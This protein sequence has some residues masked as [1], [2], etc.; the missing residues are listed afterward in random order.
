MPMLG[1]VYFP[2]DR[3]PVMPG[4]PPARPGLGAIFSGAAEQAY[5]QLRYGLPLQ[6]KTLLEVDTPQ[7]QEYYRAKLAESGV[8][9]QRAAP[10]NLSDV[11]SGRV[12]PLRFAIENLVG[13]VPYMAGGIVGAVG[14]GL[15]AGPAGAVAGAI[16]GGVPQFS[17][18]SSSRA[19]EEQGFLSE[20]AARRALLVAPLQS[21]ADAAIGRF[22]PGASKLF[23]P[24]AAPVKGGF[25]RNA[26]TNAVKA[27]IT[28]AVT[29]PLQQVG[30]RY[31]A[32]LPV[33]GSEALSEY[34][35]A[36]AA[37]FAAGGLIGGAGGFRR[38]SATSK[39]A[40][41]TSNEE[42][43]AH[44]DA[45][46]ALPSPQS[47][48]REPQVPT[49]MFVDANGRAVAGPDGI[50]TLV[51]APVADNTL[52]LTNPV[53][54]PDAPL[55]LPSPET[56]ARQP[57]GPEVTDGPGAF[58]D[59]N[60]RT[61]LGPQG[62]NTLL[63]APV[64]GPVTVPEVDFRT[65]LAE[66][67]KGLRG[68]FVQSVT[69]ENPDELLG[70]V[71]DQVFTEQ[72]TRA[73]TAKFAQRLGIL[74]DKLEPGPAALAIEAQ[75]AERQAGQGP[76]NAAV[77]GGTVTAPPAVDTSPAGVT[78]V[79]PAPISIA[80]PADPVEQKRLTAL[81]PKRVRDGALK[82]YT[83][84]SET[85]LREK[86]L[87]T[88]GNPDYSDQVEEVA[89][90]LGLLTSDDA[91]D[92]T[93]LARKT[94]L[95]S[96]QGLDEIVDAARNQGYD[97]KLASV[98]DRGAKAALS[99]EEVTSFTDFEDMTAYQAGKVWAER[100]TGNE[101][102][103][104][105]L[106]AAET[107]RQLG[108]I[109]GSTNPT[110]VEKSSINTGQVQQ[111]ALNRLLDVADLASV[112]DSDV[113]SLRRMVRDGATPSDVGQ[114]LQQVQGGK[115]LFVQPERRS[116][117]M[118]PVRAD[119][120]AQPIF[121]E[122]AERGQGPQ[123]KAAQAQES[124]TAVDT[125]RLRNLA[126]FARDEKGITEARF[127][128]LNDLLDEGKTAQ[129]A[130][131]LKDFDPDAKPA[132]KRLPTPPEKLD[133]LLPGERSVG[134]A[135]AKFEQAVTGKS[136]ME[137]ADH[138]I[139]RA[140]SRYHREIMRGVKGLAERL[141]KAGVVFDFQIVRPGDP[142][143]ARM[144]RAGNAAL[145]RVTRTPL[146]AEVYLKSMELGGDAGA[147][148]QV[149]AHEMLH[150]VTMSLVN[151]GN[152]VGVSNKTQVGKAVKDLYDLSNAVVAHF[153]TRIADGT[154]N[155]FE[156][157]IYKGQNSLANADE[158]LAWGLTNPNMQ[159]YLASI[160]YKPRQSVL[161]RLVELLRGLLGLDAKY[162]TALTE[163]LRVSEQLFKTPD[164]ELRAAFARNDPDAFATATL[165]AE[166]YAPGNFSSANRTVQAANE[167]TQQVSAMASDMVAK[168]DVRGVLDWVRRNGLGALS[169]NQLDRAYGE[170][171]PGLLDDTAAHGALVAIRNKL[172]L[173]SEN[174]VQS[175]DKLRQSDVKQDR[176]DAE[177]VTSLMQV[178]QYGIDGAKAWEDHTHLGFTKDA[179]TGELTIAKGK[180]AE[181]AAS[182]LLWDKAR[183]DYETL[184]RHKTVGVFEEARA[185]G[186]AQNLARMV[187]Q[188]RT[189]VMND[190]EYALGVAETSNPG[191]RF[192]AAEG[193]D[194]AA[195]ARDF[196][197]AELMDRL[198]A[199]KAYIDQVTG[200]PEGDPKH[201]LT[202]LQGLVAATHE[203]LASMARRPYFHLGRFGDHFAAFT[204][205]KDAKGIADPEAVRHV[206]EVLDKAGFGDVQLSADN[207]NPRVM[208]RTDNRSQAEELGRIGL[209]LKAGKW[210]DPETEVLAGPREKGDDNFGAGRQ[211]P[212]YISKIVEGLDTS[213]VYT[214]DPSMTPAE[215][216]ALAAHKNEAIRLAL[217]AWLD[218]QPDNS[219][220][221]VLAKR[222]QVQGAAKDM[223]RAFAHRQ[224]IGAIHIA[225]TL[226]RPEFVAAQ[227]KMQSAVEEAK[228]AGSKADPY[229]LNDVAVE[230]RRRA[231]GNPINP[232]ADTLDKVRAVAHANFLGLNISSALINTSAMGVTVLPE[233]GKK[234][235]YTQSFHAMRRA[236]PQAFAILNAAR[237]E[238]WAR[239]PKHA[240][241]V[242]ITEN[243]LA[244]ANIPPAIR[245]FVR[246]GVADGI[247]DIG[248]AARQLGQVAEGRGDSKLDTALRYASATSMYTE[249]FAR[250]TAGIAARELHGGT[251]PELHS[252]VRQV[253]KDTL[254]DFSPTNTGRFFGKNSPLLGPVTPIVTQFMQWNLQLTEK[255]YSE[256]KQGF[257]D[258]AATPAAKAEARRFL[259]GHMVA[260]T[261]LA[262]TLGLPFAT[263]FASV[264]EMLL[265]DEDEPFD[266]TAEWRN[267]L[268]GVLGEDMAEVVARGLPRAAGFDVSARAGEAN[269][270]P[271]SELLADKRSWKESVQNSVGRGVG[272]APNM[273]LNWVDGGEKIMNGDVLGGMAAAL[274][275]ALRNPVQAYRL[276]SE[277][278]VDTKGNKLPMTPGA[279]A[280]LWQL[281]GFAPAEKAE[282]SEARLDQS[283]RRGE[284]SR[285]AGTLRQQ[286]V[287]AMIDKDYD[288]AREL[289]AEAAVFDEKNE[290]FAVIPS[291]PGALQRQ[292]TQRTQA[293][294]LK[295][296]LGVSM[297]DVAGQGLTR[298]AN[299]NYAQ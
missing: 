255:L 224:N 73:N 196:W 52:E 236:A 51:A 50:K 269:L 247:F 191:E 22:A 86:V 283:A 174:V 260:V 223:M 217:D 97:G 128:K 291:L 3:L 2:E 92:Y 256:I 215:I 165:E 182:K 16:A 162:D 225:S 78:E 160:E 199:A 108:R 143:P 30:E 229:K 42:L 169:R 137:V 216:K 66:T 25:V 175:F 34:V 276:T 286:I 203:N 230:I 43:M 41:Q 177:R 150:A 151:Y 166:A 172:E 54:V 91:K 181:V 60:G 214:P 280:I 190:P 232:T 164:A 201:R 213:P 107:Q 170:M 239:G 179:T 36:A 70:K 116:T 262:G 77:V 192:Q 183:A 154:A 55:A 227:R 241:D 11:T 35:S 124:D 263:V 206:A 117:T 187:G 82:G 156:Q 288:T 59:A 109:Q 281:M 121:K 295:A 53:A 90:K 67:K 290:A 270:L 56:F 115:T 88:L 18:S 48:G 205:R 189:L 208:L 58:T 278:Y 106:S 194:S 271:F 113:A 110:Q 4:P 245:E 98:F 240:A 200:S 112:R 32:G 202:A 297:R 141:Q 197:M 62:I 45:V 94:Y 81:L 195:K 235:G 254:M 178:A 155:A 114:A 147:N 238:A 138:M 127:E 15:T 87:E 10:A 198:T 95:Q 253:V 89:Q 159:R 237:K 222:R 279:S 99:G 1:G 211:V 274:P 268:A 111:Q 69:A 64:P 72:D 207:S 264:A 171:L 17:A 104:R 218:N 130:R 168:L 293:V 248:T 231:A 294:A 233:L 100:Y 132:K 299:V 259:A 289:V 249:V 8:D 23:G 125:F 282:Y 139:E 145:T 221:R 277:G 140:P 287:K 33:S 9:A 158:V 219:I 123:A 244:A 265:G 84:S 209:E 273:L 188:L 26:V 27:G 19:V 47:F 85:S 20:D 234:H 246:R 251:G 75:R 80:P 180:E 65:T 63:A 186:E 163:L 40:A 173:T 134:A 44:Q 226:T 21:A 5:G 14:G 142:V 122:M 31:A 76:E 49:D 12:N 267:F 101:G 261:A 292:S 129:V 7:D 298:Y 144:N 272:A 275:A 135:D 167:V 13:S 252:Y 243:V 296:P 83:P 250:L 242:T 79:P 153:N 103:T 157:D 204:I 118:A 149:A 29:E 105:T 133:L 102:P 184:T 131:L 68:G 152:K 161:G 6:A 37:G 57:Q 28:E 96:A 258:R 71:Y 61:V 93:P 120:R 228:Q 74:D 38:T 126:R 46:L 284:L 212:D 146:R 257:F 285:R 136:F 119:R 210:L 193:M 39:P 185:D 220:N 24:L 266:A 176:N 148:Y